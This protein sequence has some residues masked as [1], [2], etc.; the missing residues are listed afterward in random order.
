MVT[1]ST[2]AFPDMPYLSNF[3]E[4][5]RLK[6]R[7]LTNSGIDLITERIYIRLRNANS[8]TFLKIGDYFW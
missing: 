8:A 4:S 6:W 3:F 2:M 5:L 1:K 7:S